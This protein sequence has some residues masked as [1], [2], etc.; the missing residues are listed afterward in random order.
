MKE[1]LKYKERKNKVIFPV[2]LKILKDIIAEGKGS[3][4]V[5]V[6]EISV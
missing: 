6:G 5:C 1:I 4:G 3:K 2:Q